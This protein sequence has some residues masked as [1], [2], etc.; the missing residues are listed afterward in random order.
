[1][2]YTIDKQSLLYKTLE[3]NEGFMSGGGSEENNN[4]ISNLEKRK[5]DRENFFKGLTMLLGGII[6][7]LYLPLLPWIKL[8][9][10]IWSRFSELWNGTLKPL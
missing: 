3:L 7:I 10:A 6:Y 9:Q 4:N 1:M 5:V 2:N 8:T